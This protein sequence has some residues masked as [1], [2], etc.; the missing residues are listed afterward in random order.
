[1]NNLE[2]R[3]EELEKEIQKYAQIEEYDKKQIMILESTKTQLLEESKRTLKELNSNRDEIFDF[4]RSNHS[5]K[6]DLKDL[7]TGKKNNPEI[8]QELAHIKRSHSKQV[9]ELE[10][11]L[12]EDMKIMG[13]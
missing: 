12:Q 9:G 13:I 6:M 3:V 11:K 8:E 5:L 2:K 7:T 1:M 10:N 4:K